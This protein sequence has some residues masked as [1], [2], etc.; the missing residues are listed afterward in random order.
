MTVC[1]ACD[2]YSFRRHARRQTQNSDGADVVS[3]YREQ[4]QKT[5]S[6]ASRKVCF[7]LRDSLRP[8]TQSKYFSLELG[9][10]PR[11]SVC[12]IA[13]ETG[14]FEPARTGAQAW[15]QIW[16]APQSLHQAGRLVARWAT[17]NPLLPVEN[18]V[19][20][21]QMIYRL[22]VA[23]PASLYQFGSRAR[24][25]ATPWSD[26]DYLVVQP[27]D[28]EDREFRHGM[29]SVSHYRLATLQA[30]AAMGSFFVQ[31]I[32]DNHVAL[33]EQD[34]R[35]DAARPH[36]RKLRIEGRYIA[37]LGWML[38]ALSSESIY[39]INPALTSGKLLWCARTAVFCRGK[40]PFRLS[41]QDPA[42][43]IL[44]LLH[45]NA[46]TK[47][48]L[49]LSLGDTVAKLQALFDLDASFAPKTVDDIRQKFA[50][51]THPEFAEIINQLQMARQMKAPEPQHNSPTTGVTHANS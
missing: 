42:F 49:P 17:L 8:L 10:L 16:V 40:N 9:V 20:I 37:E 38:S 3:E 21:P 35:L 46:R 51:D 12:R 4:D 45:Q 36:R 14:N 22:S 43:A 11:E 31:D 24:G 26:S 7:D 27:Q 34:V 25:N 48:R 50:H 39:N 19:G 6:F 15:V 44:R 5:K 32:L 41:L 29:M 33:C 1:F 28:G 2:C 13:E 18:H 47:G 30:M 23:E